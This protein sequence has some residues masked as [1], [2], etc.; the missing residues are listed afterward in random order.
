M[1]TLDPKYLEGIRRGLDAAFGRA[2]E[3]PLDPARDRVVVFSDHHKGTGDPADDF[4]RCEHAYTAALGWY[5]EAGY[6]LC[7]L[8][9]AEELWEEHPGPVIERYRDVLA[10]EAAF[11][12]RGG[13]H[14]FFGNHDDLWGAKRQ[15]A[16]HLAPVF[17][18]LE[19]LEG[20]RLRVERPGRPAAT[21]F[22]VHGHQGTADSDRWGWASR[23]FVRHVWRPLQRR[24]GFSA[25]TPARDYALRAKHDRAMYEWARTQAGGLV[26]VAGHTHRPVFGHCTPD[27][28]PTRPIGELEAALATAVAAGDR[29]RAAD[30]RAELEYARTSVR[31]P[32]EVL[33]VAPPCYFNT[34]CCSFPDGDLTGLEIADGEIR[35]VRWPANLRELCVAGQGV[36]AHKRILAT[37]DLGKV[38]DLVAD[39]TPAVA[40]ATE[41]EIRAAG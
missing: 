5:L 9:D 1:T 24:T 38:L 3:L 23:L 21:V 4:R 12:T 22:L 8:G 31:R 25:T 30:V 39:P 20:L 16:K 17:P 28:P 15:V 41:Q 36:D 10:L 29:A 35:L 2:P 34:G 27:P 13:L 14:R 18:G 7:V 37:E 33:T 40:A 11:A 19:V 6:R 32:E 26:L